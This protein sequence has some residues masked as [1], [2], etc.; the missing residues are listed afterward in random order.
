MK[1]AP[2]KYILTHF[3]RRRGFDMQMPV[4]LQ[5]VEGFLQQTVRVL[6]LQLDTKLR[7]K[8]HK[9]AVAAKIDVQILALH[10]TTAS[11]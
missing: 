9:L 1:F 4:Q 3:A 8:A 6:G 11:I 5:G 2:S 10:R 7:W